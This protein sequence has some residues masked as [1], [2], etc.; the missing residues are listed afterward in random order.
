MTTVALRISAVVSVSVCLGTAQAVWVDRPTQAVRCVPNYAEAASTDIPP[1][2]YVP[3][4]LRHAERASFPDPATAPAPTV[5]PSPTQT[6]TS[7][8]PLPVLT[9]VTPGTPTPSAEATP[10]LPPESRYFL[11]ESWTHTVRGLG[12]SMMF[13]DFPT[14]WFDEGSGVLYVYGANPRLDPSDIGYFGVGSSLSGRG[15]GQFSSLVAFRALPIARDEIELLDIT[16][17]GAVGLTRRGT[18]LRLEPGEEWTSTEVRRS[19]T[20]PGCTMTD[21]HRI[22]NYAY[23]DRSKIDY[24]LAA[25]ES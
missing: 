3:L 18:E 25:G 11:L 23:Q 6:A 8:Q 22:T 9:T 13:I 15:S 21:T 1:P 10:T 12:C 14:Y 16:E 2:A 17:K 24:S 19:T 7:T 4:A 20:E 5:S